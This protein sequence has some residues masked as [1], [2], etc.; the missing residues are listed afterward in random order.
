MTPNP[1]STFSAQAARASLAELARRDVAVLSGGTSSEREV[2][3]WTGAAILRGLR[4][5]R[6]DEEPAGPRAVHAVE[7]DADGRWRVGDERLAPGAALERFGPRCVWFLALHGGAGENGTI[8]GLLASHGL[9]HTGSGVRASAVCMDK[10]LTRLVLA[11]AGVRVAR[12]RAIDARAWRE[13]R[14]ELASELRDL[15]ARG[16]CVK[17]VHGGSSVA[18]F[19]LADARELESAIERVLAT[20]DDALIEERVRG[21]ETTCGVLG[22][23][24]GELRALTPVEIVPKD[25]RFFDFQQKY[26]AQGADEFCPPRIVTA[27]ACAAIRD[28]ALRA[29]RAAGCAGYARIDFI[30]PRDDAGAFGR[31]VALEINTLPGMTDRS[32][33]PQAARVDGLS[34]RALCLEL[35]ALALEPGAAVHEG[36]GS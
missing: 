31:P 21:I 1:S 26:D 36:R 7:I 5:P 11:D 10:H 13:R 16:A 3:T 4:S 28:D 27:D 35:L 6:G 12:G 22:N 29:F 14:G 9:A 19:L 8:Q 15:A 34:F 18:T 30:V 17:P 25:G 20:G 33:L 23:A 32:L 2:S 24:V